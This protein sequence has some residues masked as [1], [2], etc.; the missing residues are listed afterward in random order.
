MDFKFINKY[1]YINCPIY[2]TLFDLRLRLGHCTKKLSAKYINILPLR[3]NVCTLQKLSTN[4]IF[5]SL[6]NATLRMNAIKHIG[7][8]VPGPLHK[9]KSG[10]ILTT[11]GIEYKI[12]YIVVNIEVMYDCPT[13]L[14][15]GILTIR[16]EPLSAFSF[17]TF[18]TLQRL[19]L[20]LFAKK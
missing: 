18:S 11:K 1:F 10:L 4:T 9:T 15:L 14:L 19:V 6:I 16:Y 7:I 3:E 13:T 2:S 12:E 17:S 5:V 8:Q 20:S